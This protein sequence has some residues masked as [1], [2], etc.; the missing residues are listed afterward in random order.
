MEQ[1][2]PE[3]NLEQGSADYEELA[4]NNGVIVT[5]SEDHLLSMFMA[6]RLLLGMC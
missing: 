3:E 2:L 5:D 1:W 6:I 4:V